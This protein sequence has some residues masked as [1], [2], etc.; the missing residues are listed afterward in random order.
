MMFDDLFALCCMVLFI[1]LPV[2]GSIINSLPFSAILFFF[3]KRY[4]CMRFD[5]QLNSVFVFVFLF[6]MVVDCLGVFFFN[7]FVSLIDCIMHT[8]CLL[9]LNLKNNRVI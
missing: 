6:F 7:Y 8:R 2:L 1:Y 5:E 4:V 3:S 9:I